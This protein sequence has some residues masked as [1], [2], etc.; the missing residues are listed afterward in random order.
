[1]ISAL[2]KNHQFKNWPIGIAIILAPWLTVYVLREFGPLTYRP[3]SGD[4]LLFIL[5]NIMVSITA[6]SLGYIPLRSTSSYGAALAIE[7]QYKSTRIFYFLYACTVLFAL[8]SFYDY[9]IVKG[10]ALSEIV[11]N[12]ELENVTG[13]RN[14]VIGAGVA[15]LSGAPPLLIVAMMARGGTVNS[16]KIPLYIAVFFGFVAMFLSGGRNPF[17]IGLLLIFSYY[18]FFMRRRRR[19]TRAVGHKIWSWVA[20]AAVLLGVV[21]SMQLFIERSVYVGV[22]LDS[23]L[24]TLAENYELTIYRFD[25]HDS[26]LSPIY[27]IAVFLIFYITHALNYINEYFVTSY[28]PV[29]Y[30]AYSVPQLARLIDVVIGTDSFNETRAALLVNGAYLTSPGSLYLDFGY[31]GSIFLGAMLSYLFGRYMARMAKLKLI[32]RMV[33]SYLSVAFYFAPIY[34]VFGISNGF[35]IIFLLI[36]SSAV[37]VIKFNIATSRSI[38]S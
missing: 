38:H 10:A 4:F 2:D 14:S 33:L 30:G 24:D 13:P 11:A 1:M 16:K 22:D 37:S 29:F 36:I 5:I 6:Y 15:L 32:Q 8:L 9:L 7:N 35:S 19:A 31:L 25:S 34:S 27:V 12:R 21:Y 3:L 18:W 23:M 20:M 17:F 28:S 26:F